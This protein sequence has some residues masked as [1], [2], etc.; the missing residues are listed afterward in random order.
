M[1]LFSTRTKVYVA[2][3]VYNLAGDENLRPNFM[4]AT[5]LSGVLSKAKLSYGDH[6]REALRSG[7]IARQR[8]FFNW[9]KASYTYGMPEAFLGADLPVSKSKVKAGLLPLL[10]LAANQSL[11]VVA[12]VVDDPDIHYWAE[13]WMRVNRPGILDENW[14]AEWISASS[15][16]QITSGATGTTVEALLPGSSDL[17]WGIAERGRKLLYVHYRVATQ[18]TSTKVVTEGAPQLYTYRMGTGNVSFDSLVLSRE[19]VAE[20]FPVLPLRLEK[21]SIREPAYASVFPNI[22][23]GYR[24]L[25]NADIN[26][27][28]DQ[29]EDNEDIDKIDSA[30]LVQGVSL[31]TKENEG[32]NYIYRFLRNLMEWQ[33]TQ[34][35]AVP[36]FSTGTATEELEATVSW[37]RW[38]NA[39][40]SSDT[41]SEVYGAAAPVDQAQLYSAAPYYELQVKSDDLPSAD[42]RLRWCHMEESL[43]VGNCKR[44]DGNQTRS[45]AKVGDYWF[46]VGS[47]VVRR[48]AETRSYGD[49]DNIRWKGDSIQRV[50]LFH[51]Y[52]KHR[53]R[54]L[55]CIGLEHRNFVYGRHSVNVTAQEALEDTEESGFIVPMHMPTL[56]ELG[57]A[58]GSQLVTASAYLVF[59]SYKKVKRRWYQTGIFGVILAIAGIALAAI[60][61]GASLGATAGLFGTNLAVGVSLGLSGT[62]AVI[63]GA[64]ANGIAAMVVST[65]ITEAS[66]AIFGER[67]GA[68]I[69]A[70]ATFVAFTY[71]NQYAVNGNFDVDWGQ[72]LQPERLTGLTNSASQAY[73]QWL[74]ADTA[75]IQESIQDLEKDYKDQLEQ[76]EE[77]SDEILGMTNGEIDPMMLTNA[78]EYFGEPSEAFLTRTLMNGSDLVN[79]SR[80]MIENFAEI[81]LELP[82]AGIS[83][84]V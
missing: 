54:K 6:L 64:V 55:T 3:T 68:I 41:T 9:A 17:V 2:S 8:R 25:T 42:F 75:A 78:S 72:F 71:A 47:P 73:T 26:E 35:G 43:H 49:S 22:K 53:Y 74:N 1:G 33:D 80:V 56:R 57:A 19:P 82:K 69:G 83:P 36:S 59:N 4:R 15:S 63:A 77:M 46:V 70:I 58:R 24:R 44:Y 50:Y 13:H 65:L 32:R 21:Q 29:I 38:I 37:T 60:T 79:L 20:F 81:S 7:P 12:A 51:Q 10:G 39:G 40:Q 18:N 61:G 34:L 5:V 28:L 52:A 45:K 66:T 14:A 31:N 16:I 67:F 11:R 23:T 84:Y 48:I 27:L 30:Y 76:I 62:A